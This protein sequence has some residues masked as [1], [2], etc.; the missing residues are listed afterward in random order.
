MLNPGRL[1]HRI[2][3]QELSSERDSEG[4]LQEFWQNVWLDSETELANVPAEVLTGPGREFSASGAVQ[5]EVAARITCRWFPGLQQSWRILWD[6]EE[7]GIGSVEVD[8][9]ARREYRMKCTAGPSA[10]Q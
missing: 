9:T 2:T 8:R 6:G 10:G 1:R 5:A 7:F 4:V 3:F